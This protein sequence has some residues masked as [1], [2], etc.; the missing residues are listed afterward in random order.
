MVDVRKRV[1][2]FYKNST[3]KN[4]FIQ[5]LSFGKYFENNIARY[6]RDIGAMLA[7]YWRD[8]GYLGQYWPREPISHQYG[9]QY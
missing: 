3:R 2:K 6:W 9:K 1:H 8:I 5:L 4:V 7:R